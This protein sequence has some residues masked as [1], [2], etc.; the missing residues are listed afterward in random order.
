[1]RIPA[2]KVEMAVSTEESRYTLQAVKLD[3]ENKCFVATDGHILACVPAETGPEDHSAL[4]GLDVMK[5]L[6]ALDKQNKKVNG[7]VVLAITTNGKVTV[8]SL[9]SKSE[10]PVTEGTFPNWQA[11][12]P[13]METSYASL[14]E[15][16][17]D[18]QKEPR[19]TYEVSERLDK[20]IQR[21]EKLNTPIGL[22]AA[23]LH[24]LAQAISENATNKTAVVKLWIKDA[25]SGIGVQVSSSEAWGVMMPVRV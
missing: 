2:A 13:K 19:I 9:N 21:L 10:Y 3:T 4:I 12:K 25:Q 8:S 7:S 17:V 23:L 1:M 11:V 16:L 5:Q 24:R 20:V 6:R 22:D 15:E 14:R 18:I